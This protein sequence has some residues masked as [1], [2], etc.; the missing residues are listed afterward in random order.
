ML[1][2]KLVNG[3]LIVGTLVGLSICPVTQAANNNANTVA[4]GTTASSKKIQR[5]PSQDIK[6]FVSSIAIIK[7][8]YIKSVP[9]SK[10]FNNAIR[11]M[12]SRLDPHSSFL[13]KSELRDLRTTVSGQFVGIGVELTTQN[14]ALKVIA[15]LEGTPASKSGIKSGDLIIKV[16]GKLV[17]NMTLREAIKH[18]KG[19]KG[20]VVNLTIVRKGTEKPM[21]I[22]V[23]RNV[24]HLVSVKSKMLENSY[25]YVRI[26]FF[27]GPVEKK[28]RRAI[29]VLK[30]KAN[31]KLKG[32]ILD[33]RSNPGGLLDESAK[34]ADTFLNSKKI[35]RYKDLLV[36]TKGRLKGSDIKF[37]MHPGDILNGLPMIVLIN[38]GSA[39]ASEI[40]AGALQDYNRAVI[41]GTRSFGKGSVQTV[42]PINQ[43]GAI[44]LTT[45]LYHTPAGRVIQ[46]RGIEP[47][48][49]V[50]NLEVS[51][52]KIKS[53][54]D[55]DE[56]DFQNHLQNG[57]MQGEE[58]RLEALRKQRI[59]ELKLAK[60]DY[61]LYEALLVL[62]GMS[63]IR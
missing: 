24:I 42:F 40:V 49:L 48:V 18:I 13:D 22:G 25:G 54:I 16:D 9:D 14:G 56:S 12:V 17:Q 15:P 26:T 38:G 39:S 27:Q 3:V 23:I 37:K 43:D 55:V 33:L 41:M 11:G 21:K 34:V 61:Q 63:A 6:R 52:K 60:D 62:K 36:Y 30:A 50:P 46:A 44:K 29:N 28:L 2:R 47:N 4:F 20:T 8:Y 35:T 57:D 31:G 59:A 45:A 5:L 19:K 51:S 53:L 1:V 58:Q 32:L 10:L 7:R